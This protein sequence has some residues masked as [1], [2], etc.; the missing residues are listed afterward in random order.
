MLSY[1]PSPRTS[2]IEDIVIITRL[3]INSYRNLKSIYKQYVINID[4]MADYLNKRGE[5]KSFV[6]ESG[7]KTIII[8][9]IVWVV[10]I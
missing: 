2:I 10:K 1:I 7:Y 3:I 9:S 5:S 6:N 4:I 8:L